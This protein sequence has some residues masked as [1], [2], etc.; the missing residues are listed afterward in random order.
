MAEMEILERDQQPGIA[1]EALSPRI[2]Q[3]VKNVLE[4]AELTREKEQPETR[5]WHYQF[6]GAGVRYYSFR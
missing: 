1:V 5:Q 6:G 4:K 2:T 3:D